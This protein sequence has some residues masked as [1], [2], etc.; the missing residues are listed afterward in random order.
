MNWDTLWLELAAS[1]G[2]I[3][4]M[5]GAT[6][7][8]AAVRHQHSIMDTV[9]G[10]GFVLI[11]ALGFILTSGHGN[12]VR[13]VIVLALVA[14]WGLRLAGHIFWRNKG[15]GEDPR[16]AAL[17]RH[18]TGNPTLFVLRTIYWAQGWVMWIVALPIE[19]AMAER[20]PV[21]VVT[22]FGIAVVGVGMFFEIT[23][24]LQLRRFKADPANAGMVMDR[25]LWRYTRHPNYFGDSC[26]WFG[27][28]LV[29]CSSWVGLV[30]VVSPLLMTEMLVRQTGKALLE[31]HLTRSKGDAYRAYIEC[32]SGFIPWPPRSIP[33]SSIPASSFQEKTVPA[34]TR[35]DHLIQEKVHEHR[36]KGTI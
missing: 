2:L 4:I 6:F 33:A 10:L 5:L 35:I 29:A 22:G 12:P 20:M 16:Y 27:L 28:F 9:W 19:V 13:R 18:S 3:V 32:T 30:T 23:G 1:A 24:D 36:R 8:V 21:G 31:K 11:A 26:V 14:I 15:K 17:L 34:D 25:G 7:W